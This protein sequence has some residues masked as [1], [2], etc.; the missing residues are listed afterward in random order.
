LVGTTGQLVGVEAGELLTCWNCGRVWKVQ[1]DHTIISVEELNNR[2]P[3]ARRA[4]VRRHTAKGDH[5]GR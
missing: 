5:H 2:R 1:P 3:T 4:R